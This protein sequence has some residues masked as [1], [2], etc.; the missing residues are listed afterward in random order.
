M[1]RELHAPRRYR[2]LSKVPLSVSFPSV[3]YRLDFAP[4]FGCPQWSLEAN[5]LAGTPNW[6]LCQSGDHEA[7]VLLAAAVYERGFEVMH[8]TAPSAIMERLC[9]EGRAECL[10]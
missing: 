4:V 3:A 1:A 5:S 9:R 10:R 2:L 6:K 7:P 8:P